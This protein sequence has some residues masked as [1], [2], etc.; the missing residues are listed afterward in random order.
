MERSSNDAN[1]NEL[2]FHAFATANSSLPE[3]NTMFQDTSS[4]PALGSNALGSD[5]LW[6]DMFDILDWNDTAMGWSP[7]TS[8]ADRAPSGSVQWD[9]DESGTIL[10]E[11]R[12]GKRCTNIAYSLRSK[13][14]VVSRAEP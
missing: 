13:I 12:E 9:I 8:H 10:F 5:A 3:A 7:S 14:Q 6:L 1:F 11:I 4:L 2:V